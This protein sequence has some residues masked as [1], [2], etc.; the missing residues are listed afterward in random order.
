M[1]R[2]CKHCGDLF[3]PCANVAHQRYCCEA[4]CQKA[5][6][7]EW[8][9]KKLA[10]DS[11]YRLNQ[12]DAQKRWR[13]RHPEYW[14]GYRTSHPEY[15]RR[16]RALQRDRNHKRREGVIAKSDESSICNPMRSGYYRLI[17]AEAEAIAKRDEYLVKLDV[18]PRGYLQVPDIFPDCKQIT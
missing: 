3:T 1:E 10:T 11:D 13:Q 5:R 12:Y 6:K 15:A 2:R 7:N 8:R 16:N 9:K 18:I 17:P 4:E 14:G